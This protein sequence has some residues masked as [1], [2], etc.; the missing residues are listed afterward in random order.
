[1]FA[2]R[3]FYRSDDERVSQITAASSGKQHEFC[4]CTFKV[5]CEL[6]QSL[7][8]SSDWRFQIWKGQS[9][10]NTLPGNEGRIGHEPA[11][12][13]VGLAHECQHAHDDIG[14][15]YDSIGQR[16]DP[17]VRNEETNRERR[18]YRNRYQQAQRAAE[19]NAVRTE[20]WMRGALEQGEPRSQY[21]FG[22]PH[23][24]W[25]HGTID[26]QDHDLFMEDADEAWNRCC[27]KLH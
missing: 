9:F 23:P 1:L 14:G 15:I 20:N 26:I 18:E 22:E 25:A 21:Q 19:T 11:N 24:P 6:L 4:L 3:R 13:P 17:R 8:T 10:Y 2:L 16:P 27:P 7:I 5:G 12:G